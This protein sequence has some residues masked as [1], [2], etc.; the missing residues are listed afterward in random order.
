MKPSKISILG[1]LVFIFCITSSNKPKDE[2]WKLPK[3]LK[4]RYVFVPQFESDKSKGAFY[5]SIYE[6]SNL[7][8]REF[9]YYLK[10]NNQ[11]EKLAVA[12]I[13]S[14]NWIE[15][16]PNAFNRPFAE[17]YHKHHAYDNYPVM[18]VSLD[19]AKLYCEWLT[20][21]WNEKLAEEDYRLQFMIPNREQWL[22]AANGGREGATYSWEGQS[23]RGEDGKLKCNF[24]ALGAEHIYYDSTTNNYGVK[25]ELAAKVKIKDDVYI[26]DKAL[27]TAPTN[28]Y[29]VYGWGLYNLNGNVA[30][31]VSEGLACGGSWNSTGYD[32]RNESVIKVNHS[33]SMVGFRPILVFAKKDK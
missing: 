12:K 33:S 20:E 21:I 10:N 13:D 1:I 24:K 8:Y 6:V 7:D 4:D 14:S 25:S 9:L 27:I 5:I 29:Q 3:L 23:L 15:E 32:V 31:W 28:S 18:N 30:E 2:F 17:H 26:S 11:L 16:F 19:A 22:S